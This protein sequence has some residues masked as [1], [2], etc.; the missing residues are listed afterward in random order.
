MDNELVVDLEKK[1]ATLVMNY[2]T[3]TTED[4][5]ERL[6]YIKLLS[7]N[8]DLIMRV[9][10]NTID[11]NIRY[12]FGVHIPETIWNMKNNSFIN[13]FQDKSL[14]EYWDQLCNEAI[15]ESVKKLYPSVRKL[16]SEAGQK[17]V[18]GNS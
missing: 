10:G 9:E 1:T 6:N 3:I 2:I 8:K 5:E 17:L 16:M 12:D 18:E 4:D 14:K 13:G 11:V 7:E 15:L